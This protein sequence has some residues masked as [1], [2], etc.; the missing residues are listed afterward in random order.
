MPHAVAAAVA[1]YVTGTTIGVSLALAAAGGAYAYVAVYAATYLATT[2]LIGSAIGKFAAKK[3]GGAA[4]GGG[5]MSAVETSGMSQKM[6][7]TPAFSRRKIYGETLISGNMCYAESS[8]SENSHLDLVMVLGEGEIEGIT[9]MRVGDDVVELDA[10]DEGTLRR[11]TSGNKYRNLVQVFVHNGGN[12]QESDSTLNGRQSNWTEDHRLRGIAYVYVR[13]RY[14]KDIF[15]GGI[16]NLRFIVKGSK[17]YDPR[18]DTANGYSGAG[19]HSATDSATWEWTDNPILCLRDFLTLPNGLNAQASEINEARFIEMANECDD[20]IDLN[21]DGSSQQKRYRLNGP[22]TLDNTKA[23]IAEG[24]LATCNGSLIWTQGQYVPQVGVAI[25]AS[26][27]HVLTADN[28]RAGIK[29][30]TKTP[31]ANRLN[32]VRGMFVDADNSYQVADFAPI[33]NTTYQNE[34]GEQLFGDIDLALVTDQAQAQRLA[35]QVLEGNRQAIEVEFFG[36]LTCFPIAINDTVTLTIDPDG[37]GGTNAIFTNK[38]FLVVNWKFNGDGGVDLKLREYADAMFDWAYGEMTTVDLAPNTT[39]ANPLDVPSVGLSVSTDLRTVRGKILSA[40]VAQVTSSSPLIDNVEV[41]Y[42]KSTDTNFTA[43]AVAAGSGVFR[44]EVLGIETTNY[45]VQVRAINTLGVVGNFAD[46]KVEN[47]FADALGAVP[48]DVT[49]FTGNVIGSSVLFL[50]WTPVSDLD[51][52]HYLIR[53]STLTSG[54]T[55]QEAEDVAT[56]VASS[57]SIS[58]PA[59]AG[60][61]FIKA[62]DDTT[63]GSNVSANAASVAINADEI[64]ALNTVQAVTEN[65]SFSGTKTNITPN[66]DGYLQLSASGGNFA[67]SGIYYFNTT[68]DLG[69]KYTSRISTSYTLVRLDTTNTFDLAT[70]NFDDRLGFFDGDVTAFND[71]SVSTEVRYTNNDPSSSPTYGDWQAF[72]VSDIVARAIQFRIVL[73]TTDTNVTP[74]ISALTAKVD[75]PDRTV[76][77]GNIT[78]TGTKNITFAGPFKTIPAVGLSLQN[79]VNGDRYTITNKTR[80]GFTINTFTNSSTSTNPVTFDYVAN[81]YGKELS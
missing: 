79:L 8:G 73:T 44:A 11:P 52:A 6:S 42:K 49:N 16:P 2:A 39:L 19:P 59:A 56:V 41:Q 24:I 34:D 5:A 3:M 25:P 46:T 36:N 70:G 81:G 65:P 54:A 53:Y 14:D 43:V 50:T 77:E 22:I 47:F 75:M 30:T 74:V 45:D 51:L 37:T 31:K 61:Y 68:V 71:V 67:N 17:L 57:S 10:G 48:A 80:T 23:S 72:T 60:T 21:A 18:K 1:T 35:K 62:V 12:D 40:L 38:K 66:S 7:F 78:F 13:L 26:R 27:N 4:G 9:A 76:A 58:I 55:Y 15:T 63:S 32:A 28:L 33:K 64:G 20:L 29:F 69:Q